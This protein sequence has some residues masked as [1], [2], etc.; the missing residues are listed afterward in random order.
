MLLILTDNK[1]NT[2]NRAS[3]SNTSSHSSKTNLT[4]NH[5]RQRNK[6]NR[7]HSKVDL[8]ALK[9]SHSNKVVLRLKMEDST[10]HSNS[11]GPLNLMEP[12]IDFSDDIPF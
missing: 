11:G 5:I 1:A 10:P 7:Q 2:N 6:C 4:N 12:P 3:N 8:I 9:H